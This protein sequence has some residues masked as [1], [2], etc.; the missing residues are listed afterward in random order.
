MKLP[1]TKKECLSEKENWDDIIHSPSWVVFRNLLK[2]HCAYL[3]KETNEY[4]EK[5]E[6][7]KAGESLRAMKDSNKI[8]T[9]VTQRISELN[10]TIEQGGK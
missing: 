7:R 10:K 8:L 3:Q 4:L 9:L 2:E 5:H 6:D 1:E